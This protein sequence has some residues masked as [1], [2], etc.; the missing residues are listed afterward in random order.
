M[1]V[2]P[3]YRNEAGK[4]DAA[5]DREVTDVT[6]VEE[7]VHRYY[8]GESDINTVIAFQEHTMKGQGYIYLG[9]HENTTEYNLYWC[10]PVQAVVLADKGEYQVRIWAFD[11]L[12][13]ARR[14]VSKLQPITAEITLCI[15]FELIPAHTETIGDYLPAN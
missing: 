3:A 13:D 4:F 6:S 2:Y 10:P 14:M 1:N 12:P 9:H 8:T 7:F 5:Y 15:Q 11:E